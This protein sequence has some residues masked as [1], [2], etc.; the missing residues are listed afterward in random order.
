MVSHCGCRLSQAGHC[1][2]CRIAD[3]FG[4]DETVAGALF[5]ITIRRHVSNRHWRWRF[6]Q[7]PQRYSKR[8]PIF[9]YSSR[10]CHGNANVCGVLRSPQAFCWRFKNQTKAI[11]TRIRCFW[12]CVNVIR[13]ID[14]SRMIYYYLVSR[15]YKDVRIFFLYPAYVS[16]GMINMLF[17]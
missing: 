17:M 16:I 14:F 11:T 15:I 9:G 3:A 13:A 5:D 2:L 4:Q 7:Q 6:G 1:G 8:A 10:T 12:F